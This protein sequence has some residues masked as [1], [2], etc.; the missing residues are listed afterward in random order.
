MKFLYLTAFLCFIAST[1]VL[2]M[3]TGDQAKL[4]RKLAIIAA[5]NAKAAAK[6]QAAQD[7]ENARLEMAQK[8]IDAHLEK[9][10]E[11]SANKIRMQEAGQRQ[12]EEALIKRAEH[13]ARVVENNAFVAAK[14]AQWNAKNEEN[15]AKLVAKGNNP[16]W[17]RQF[18][19]P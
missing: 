13:E 14:E 15:K 2:S 11:T 19:M 12:K 17:S 18:H 10:A 1:T 6:R 5:K 3:P 4:Q 7:L 9:V 16:A 8:Y